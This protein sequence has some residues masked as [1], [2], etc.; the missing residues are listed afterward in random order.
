MTLKDV[1]TSVKKIV[2]VRPSLSTLVQERVLK[3]AYFTAT[4]SAQQI[5]QRDQEPL[6][7]LKLGTSK[8]QLPI[9]PNVLTYMLGKRTLFMLLLAKSNVLKKH[10]TIQHKIMSMHGTAMKS[11]SMIVFVLK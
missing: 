9:P 11:N 8:S 5:Q 4:V 7:M 3:A 1:I 10:V 6:F 2:S